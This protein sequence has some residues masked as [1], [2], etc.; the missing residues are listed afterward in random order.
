M[1]KIR[2]GVFET[3]SSSTHTLTIVSK[4]EFEKWENGDLSFD[5]YHTCLIPITEQKE[6]NDDDDDDDCRYQSYEEWENDDDLEIFVNNYK[7]KNGDEIVVFGKFGYN[8]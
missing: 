5:S 6:C 8:G 1:K 2:F 4:E 3:N 7:S